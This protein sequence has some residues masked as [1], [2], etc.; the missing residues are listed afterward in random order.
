MPW[1]VSYEERRRRRGL[2]LAS[3]GAGDV[4]GLKFGDHVAEQ[5]VDVVDA[6]NEGSNGVLGINTGL[7]FLQLG[8]TVL[9]VVAAETGLAYSVLVAVVLGPGGSVGDVSGGHCDKV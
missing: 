5:V 1:N 6:S 8:D 2:T 4:L 7:T 9:V 3:E